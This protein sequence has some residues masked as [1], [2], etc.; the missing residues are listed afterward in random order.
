MFNHNTPVASRTTY[1]TTDQLLNLLADPGVLARACTVV[2]VGF[3]WVVHVSFTNCAAR[4]LCVSAFFAAKETLYIAL[5][6]KEAPG[7]CDD[8]PA[9]SAW[10]SLIQSFYE[11]VRV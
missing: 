8:T 3:G 4:C 1:N 5:C 10:R 2:C 6:F 11:E 9:S 7:I